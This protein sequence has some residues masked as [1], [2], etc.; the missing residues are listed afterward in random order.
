MRSLVFFGGL[1]ACNPRYTQHIAL[2]GVATADQR[3]GLV[4]HE[5]AP[6]DAGNA[7]GMGFVAHINHVGLAL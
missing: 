1:N 4:L 7:M 3:Q 2:F 5:D 6:L